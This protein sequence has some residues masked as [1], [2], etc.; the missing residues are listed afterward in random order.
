MKL[1]VK[2]N[3][4]IAFSSYLRNVIN[5]EKWPWIRRGPFEK[6]PLSLSKKAADLYEPF[7]LSF[8]K[9]PLK[10]FEENSKKFKRLV[11]KVEQLYNKEWQRHQKKLRTIAKILREIVQEYGNFIAK[12][13]PSLTRKKWRYSEV[14]LIPSL[15]SGG[16]VVD[17]KIF[18]G[19]GKNLR[20]RCI[21]LLTH[22]L[23]HVNEPVAEEDFRKKLKLPMDSREIATVLLTNKIIER[24]NKKFKL[25]IPPQGFHTYYEKLI[26]KYEPGLRKLAKTKKS[27]IP[28]IKAVDEFLAKKGYK[29]YYSKYIK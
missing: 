14:W 13:I 6:I 27:Y 12:T 29:G 21:C 7:K 16:T 28:L 10:D 24:L 15:Y 5:L 11:E 25:N 9:H 20:E 17:N 8:E 4:N 23:I 1:K 2:L 22:E 3:K 26:K 19:Y 18:I